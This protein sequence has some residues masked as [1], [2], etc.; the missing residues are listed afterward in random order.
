DRSTTLLFSM[1]RP[2][3]TSTLFPYTTLFRSVNFQT[4][5]SGTLN[6]DAHFL[7]ATPYFGELTTPPYPLSPLAS[8]SNELEVVSGF[9]LEHNW[10]V[11]FVFQWPENAPQSSTG[12]LPVG[13]LRAVDGGASRSAAEYPNGSAARIVIASVR[14][15]STPVKLN[16]SHD[17][18]RGDVIEVAVRGN[19]VQLFADIRVGG[20]Q[21]VTGQLNLTPGVQSPFEQL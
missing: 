13:S 3:P 5:Q 9:Q 18:L 15:G 11:G 21:P 20:K 2:P 14:P 19:A 16:L 17:L 7:I 6:T 4:G 12:R 10:S 1:T 8:G